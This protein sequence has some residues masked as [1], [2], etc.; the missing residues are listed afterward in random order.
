ML[1][2]CTVQFERNAAKHHSAWSR[3]AF[4]WRSSRFWNDRAQKRSINGT[5]SFTAYS[6][7]C[8][9][10]MFLWYGAPR[11]CHAASLQ[12]MRPRYGQGRQ[13]A[14]DRGASPAPCLQV[15]RLPRGRHYPPGVAG[16]TPTTS[17]ASVTRLATTTVITSHGFQHS[18]YPA[19]DD[20]GRCPK[21]SFTQDRPEPHRQ[22]KSTAIKSL[23]NP[24][25]GADRL[26]GFLA[27]TRLR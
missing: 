13:A 23:Y 19:D 25:L 16:R 10:G 27:R 9:R 26:E 11:K 21:S 20:P 4:R 14:S 3:C 5:R 7:C 8:S 22:C 2:H 15:R 6:P 17:A 24:G 12:K 18:N 1:G